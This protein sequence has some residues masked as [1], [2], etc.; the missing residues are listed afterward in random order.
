MRICAK[1][2]AS[3]RRVVRN[4]R[5]ADELERQ[6]YSVE[7]DK[8]RNGAYFA[9]IGN[10]LEHEKEV[11]RIFAENGF[12]FTLDREGN[13][14]VRIKGRLYTLP[15]VDG[16]VEGFTHEIAAL[17]G[18]PDPRTVARAISHSHKSFV[19]DQS[20]SVQAD[21]AI[22]IAPLGSKYKMEHIIDGISEYVRQAAEGESKAKPLLYLHVEEDARAIYRWRI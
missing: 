21:I 11:G 8:H 10:H 12:S 19:H 22:T 15:S 9:V 14:K 18:E 2:E 13:V 16:R 1:G 7:R 5:D 3:R 17:R 4:N 6:G 20:K